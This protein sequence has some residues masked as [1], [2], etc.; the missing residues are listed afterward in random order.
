MERGLK[1]HSWSVL[2]FKKT[3]E[4]KDYEGAL[5]LKMIEVWLVAGDNL[6]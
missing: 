2:N 4:Y 1:S 6:E 5:S 3:Y